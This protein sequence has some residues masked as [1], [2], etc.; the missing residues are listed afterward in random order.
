RG[1]SPVPILRSLVLHPAAVEAHEIAKSLYIRIPGMLNE[2]GKS[3]RQSFRQPLFARIVER[4]G[5][6]QRAG[7]V[8]DAIAVGAVRYAMNGMLKQSCVV[9]HR[10]EMAELHFWRRA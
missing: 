6:K 8:V 5:H 9:A 3:R 1:A 4:T 7:V 10:Q 2:G